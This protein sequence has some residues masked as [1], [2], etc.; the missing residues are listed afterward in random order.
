MP[1]AR[2]KIPHEIFFPDDRRREFFPDLQPRMPTFEDFYDYCYHVANRGR[3]HGHLTFLVFGIP[4]ALKSGRE[5]R[6][7]AVSVD[8]TCAM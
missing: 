5:M 3:P 1:W 6:Q 8:H 4:E 2:Y 7:S